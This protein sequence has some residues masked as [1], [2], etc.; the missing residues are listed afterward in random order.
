LINEKENIT[1]H[2]EGKD[3]EYIR[4]RDWLVERM[5]KQCWKSEDEK[6]LS[7]RG[8]K[9]KEQPKPIIDQT[10]PRNKFFKF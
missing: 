5:K 6:P 4:R 2:D 8:R 10:K 7:K 1:N 3:P 9:P